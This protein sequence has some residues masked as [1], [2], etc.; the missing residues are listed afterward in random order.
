M[1]S[2]LSLFDLLGFPNYLLEEHRTRLAAIR[3]EKG[4]SPS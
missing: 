4:D 1:S 3:R 2:E